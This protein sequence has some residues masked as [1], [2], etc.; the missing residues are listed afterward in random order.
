VCVDKEI[1]DAEVAY[2]TRGYPATSRTGII[3]HR[4]AIGEIDQR[5]G[6]RNSEI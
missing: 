4:W 1:T 2:R 3:T 6:T 5:G